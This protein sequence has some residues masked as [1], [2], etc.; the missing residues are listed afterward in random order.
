MLYTVLYFVRIILFIR[1]FSIWF[2]ECFV[3]VRVR[4]SVVQI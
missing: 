1:L 3:R 4:D 2:C